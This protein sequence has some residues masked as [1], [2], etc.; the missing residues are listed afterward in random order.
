[1]VLLETRRLAVSLGA[2]RSDPTIRGWTLDG[3]S[4]RFRYA[5]SALPKHFVS[6][7]AD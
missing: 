7:R 4:I 1:M 2:Y 6:C 5:S 3:A